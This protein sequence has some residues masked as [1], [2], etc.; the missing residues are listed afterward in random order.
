MSGGVWGRKVLM[1]ASVAAVGLGFLIGFGPRGFGRAPTIVATSMTSCALVREVLGD[2]PS[3]AWFG[4]RSNR[5]FGSDHDPKN[6]SNTP[7][8]HEG[9]AYGT[10]EVSGSRTMGIFNYVAYYDKGAWVVAHATL[11]T[12]GQTI[13]V[14]RCSR[15]E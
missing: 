1:A 10:Y 3:A 2:H 8:G 6:R 13:D 12:N 14:L 11:R 15:V 4:G 7:A 5:V 9:W